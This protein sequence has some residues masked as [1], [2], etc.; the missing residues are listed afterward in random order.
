MILLV[1]CFAFSVNLARAEYVV[2]V[3]SGD[4]I[5]YGVTVSY[6]GQSF[7]GSMK[8]T[9]QTVQGSLITGTYEVTTPG[10]GGIPPQQ[11]TQ[12]FTLD[13]LT[14]SSQYASGFI[15]PANLTVGNA[16]PGEAVTVQAIVDWHGRKAIAAN[17]S[18]P[19]MGFSGQIYWDQA[20][21]VFLDSTGSMRDP[22][23]GEVTYG[24]SLAETSLWSG[25][26]FGLD[27]TMWII[28]IVVIVVV[29]AVVGLMLIR[30][31]AQPV[32][33][34]PQAGQPPPPPPPAST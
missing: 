17:A 28:I 16:I 12:P 34:L 11:I 20:T 6:Q 2:G 8:L 15:I 10:Y 30:R 25:G 14:G 23:L 9:I 33:A 24:I 3:K 26:L 32:P 19:Y 13:V 5:R 4:W 31:R 29:V 18:I 27:L 21:G 1:F 22:T 7:K